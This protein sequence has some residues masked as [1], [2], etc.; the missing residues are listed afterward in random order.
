MTSV[1]I[2]R[3]FG[4]L[5]SGAKVMAQIDSIIIRTNSL[6]SLEDNPAMRTGRIKFLV[7]LPCFQIEIGG[8]C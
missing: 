6:F 7:K 2:R 4:E 8:H 1:K 5:G 3:L